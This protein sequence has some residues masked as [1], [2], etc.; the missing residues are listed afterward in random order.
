MNHTNERTPSEGILSFDPIVLL[1]DVAKRWLL[2]LLVA[3]MA[4]VGTYIIKDATYAP[5]YKTT[6]TFVVTSQDSSATVYSNLT[7]ASSL[8]TV[9]SDLLNSSILR[10]TIL[11][12][13]DLSGFDGTIQAGAIPETNLLT[14]TVTGS[15]PRSAYLMAKGIIA[16][17]GELTYQ[18]VDGISLDVLQQPSV[19]TAPSNAT[20]ATG[21][22]KRMALL[23]AAAAAAVLAFLSFKKDALRSGTEVQKKLN[24]NYLGEIAHEHKYKTLISK[25]RRP[26]SSILITNPTTSFRFLE[27][28][29]KLRR[30]V[31][32]RMGDNKILLVTSLL[33]NEGKS[34]VAVNLA[35]ALAQKNK[36]VLLID[37]DL[38]KPAC[39]ALLEQKNVVHGLRDVL[40][41]GTPLG[42]ALRQDKKSGLCMLL[43]TRGT[44]NSGD[45]VS[46]PAMQDLLRWARTEFDYVVLD[47]PP[48]A[49]VSDAESMAD[50]A[51][52]SLL[53]VRQNVSMATSVNKSIAALERGNAKFL[54]CVLNNVISS[55]ISSGLTYGYGYGYGYGK[56]G[57]YG[58]YGHYGSDT[59]KKE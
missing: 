55:P 31:E 10:K 7:S 23:A 51:D 9:F 13:T 29:R 32:H 54:G 2:I 53:V 40:T 44:S 57:K 15:D 3:I 19:P 8:A 50:I 20:N 45:L 21:L 30:R 37:C 39:H 34:T 14:M 49:A 27:S 26:K 6:T 28:I 58:H 35:L 36:E 52:A 16:H 17:H 47:M 46:G 12:H 41:K 5:V 56:Y 4:G 11:Q 22:M 59:H 42:E 48:M 24:C 33:E 38:R 25:I 43:E 18:I 1:M